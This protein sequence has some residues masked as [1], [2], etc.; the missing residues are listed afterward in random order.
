MEEEINR[1]GFYLFVLF[2]WWGDCGVFVFFVCLLAF[3]SRDKAWQQGTTDSTEV[4]RE[5]ARKTETS[6]RINSY[7]FLESFNSQPNIKV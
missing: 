6:F 5:I 2:C 1:K 3:Y 4:I 7:L